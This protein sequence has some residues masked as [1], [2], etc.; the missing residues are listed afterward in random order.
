MST[1]LAGLMRAVGVV[2]FFDR[3]RTKIKGYTVEGIGDSLVTKRPRKPVDRMK[4]WMQK[5]CDWVDGLVRPPEPE[6][7]P[8]PVHRPGRRPGNPSQR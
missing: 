3:P 4:E 2:I 6:L 1:N 8:V 5:L 7:I